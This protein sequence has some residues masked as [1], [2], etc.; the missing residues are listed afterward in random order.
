MISIVLAALKLGEMFFD[1]CL[2]IYYSHGESP[3]STLGNSSAAP[4]STEWSRYPF[5]TKDNGNE[6]P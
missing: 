2:S 6:K 4:G 3:T 1:V 5:F